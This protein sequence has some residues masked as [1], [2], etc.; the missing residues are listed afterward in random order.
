MPKLSRSTSQKG[1]VSIFIVVFTALLVTIISVSFIRIMV[2]NQQQATAADLS[3]SA[4][5]SAQAGVEDAKRLLVQYQTQC[6][7]TSTPAS[8]CSSLERLLRVDMPCNTIQ[9]AGIA[10]NIDDKEVIV[11]Q[12]ENDEALQQAYTCVKVAANTDDYIGGVNT[13]ASRLVP[14]KGTG[15]F[16]QVVLEWFSQ[17]DLQNASDGPGEKT[18]ELSNDMQLPKLKEWSKNRPSL[19]RIQLIQ[20]GSSF[21]LTDFDKLADG[22][23]NAHTLFLDPSNIGR[24]SVDFAED[25]RLSQSAGVLQPVSCDRNFSTSS[26][27]KNFACRVVLNLP[28]PVGSSDGNNRTAYL[29]LDPIYNSLTHFRVQLQKD[30]VV[31]KFKDVQPIIDSTGRAND[32]FRRI[33]SRVELESDLFPY[34]E[35]A[36]D[37]TGSLCKAFLVTDKPE[38]YSPGLCDPQAH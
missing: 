2:Q 6:L 7:K 4:Y 19:M 13:G 32:L 10:G 26:A 37:I 3:Q 23:S 22:S 34:P 12:G 20:F 38:N 24:D 29:R 31:T 14:L 5:D 18:I 1:A 27:D 15:A 8:Q 16:N 35:S 9:Q 30:N 28:N 25:T 33:Q 17:V 21:K 11:K 36:I